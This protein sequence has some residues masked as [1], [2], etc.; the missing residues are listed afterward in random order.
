M[1]LT[2]RIL[3]WQ[4]RV[5]LM[6]LRDDCNETSKDGLHHRVRISKVEE[7]AAFVQDLEGQNYEVSRFRY[8]VES[9]Y[10]RYRRER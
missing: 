10:E 6:N 1:T 5:M 2:K 4:Y 8:V 9:F 7:L 3:P